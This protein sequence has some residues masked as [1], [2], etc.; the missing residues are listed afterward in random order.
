[1]TRAIVVAL[2]TGA[3][4]SSAA[5]LG[6]AGTG[7]SA[8]EEFS[9]QAYEAALREVHALRAAQSN[10]CEAIAAGEREVCRARIGAAALVRTAEI[11]QAYRRTEQSARA[12]QRARIEARYQTDRARCQAAGGY[13][14]EKCLVKAHASRGRSL[15]QASA[16]YETRM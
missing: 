4:I 8:Q 15:M 16:P 5:A 12:L 13:Q 3:F 9:R 2:G 6:I 11:D 1:M 7:N 10:A 14:R